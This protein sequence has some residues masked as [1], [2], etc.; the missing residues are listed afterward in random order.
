GDSTFHSPL[1]NPNLPRLNELTA[2]DFN[3]DG[4][5]DVAAL[6]ESN[7]GIAILL[8][9]GDGTFQAPLHAAW[10]YPVDSFV[11]GDF[12]G[13]GKLDLALASNTNNTVHVGVLLGNGE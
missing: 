12:N 3:H 5:L 13:D 1:V 7:G 11:V 6:D 10:Q 8:G 4:N 9:N 2:G